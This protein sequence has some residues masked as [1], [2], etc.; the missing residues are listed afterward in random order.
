MFFFLFGT[1]KRKKNNLVSTK[2]ATIAAKKS[3][4]EK[5]FH[6]MRLVLLFRIPTDQMGYLKQKKNI[7]GKKNRAKTFG[8]K[9][10]LE[11]FRGTKN[12]YSLGYFGRNREINK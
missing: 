1:T 7:T 12:Y 5:A 8:E 4:L 6:G 11:V 2:S 10:A 9:W 3:D